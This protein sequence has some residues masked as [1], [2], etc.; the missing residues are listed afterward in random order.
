M[1]KSPEGATPKKK[2]FV[3][4]TNVILHDSSCIFEFG[5]NDVYIPITVLEELDRFKKGNES[6]NFH[7]REFV[8]TLDELMEEPSIQQGARIREDLG[9]LYVMIQ[10]EVHPNL[11]LNLD[12]K[13]DNQI[14]S[15]AYSL[16]K[17]KKSPV[18]LVSKDVNLR[19]KAKSIG[20]HAEDYYT[21][22]VKNIS[23]IDKGIRKIDGA[24]EELVKKIFDEND[25]LS[26]E[27][28][29][30]DPPPNPNEYFIFKT[31]PM[32]VLATFDYKTNS[33]IKVDRQDVSRIRPRN[34]EQIFSAD[35]LINPEIPLVAL[36][37]KAGTGK[38]LLALAAALSLE[39]LYYQIFLSR[40]VVPL[41]NRDMG[42]LPGDI[43]SKMDPYIKPL[44]DNLSVIQNNYPKNDHGAEKIDRMLDEGKLQISPLSY[45]RGRSLVNTY[46]IV[47][48]AQNLTPHE[49]KTV[50]T[51]AGEGTKI[52]LTGDVH[53]IDHPYLDSESN[54]LSHV[55]EKFKGSPLFAHVSLEK[56]ERSELAE[57]ASNLL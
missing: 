29:K 14:L 1:T 54:G 47:D 31:P 37:G 21:D 27:E 17:S 41:S 57:I 38:T 45:I 46:F 26:Q 52:I 3:L 15:V 8:R 7:A 12:D 11:Q 56:G 16:A 50:I 6:L 23:L 49:I 43:D 53:Q 28:L 19:M 10:K 2:N 4:D 25:G 39:K 34:A 55:I 36:S 18:V 30:L 22:K 24:P 51:R 33:F 48:E 44:Y 20:V 42:Y 32:S 40:P 9:K 35:A 13:P 5:N